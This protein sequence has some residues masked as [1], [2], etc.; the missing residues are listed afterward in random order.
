MY[1]ATS[2][3]PSG[4]GGDY[5]LHNFER[6]EDRRRE[7]FKRRERQS[8]KKRMKELQTERPVLDTVFRLSTSQIN[9]KRTRSSQISV[10]NLNVDDNGADNNPEDTHPLQPTLAAEKSRHSFLYLMLSPH[11]RTWQAVAFRRFITLVIMTDLLLF[12]WSTDDAFTYLSDDFYRTA[13]GITS[14]IFLLEYIGRVYT[15]GE[16]KK[17]REMGPIRGRL[18]FMKTFAAVIDL[19]AALPFFLEI[20]TGWNLPTLT[21]LRFLRLFRILKS[22][23]YVKALDAVYRVIYFNRQILYVATLVCLFLVLITSILLYYCRPR[24]DRTNPL[25]ESLG[26]TMYMSTLMLTGGGAPDTED[27]PFM[28]KAVVLLTSVFSVAMFAIP[29]SM[30]TWGFEAEA[31]RMAKKARKRALKRREMSKRGSTSFCSS[32]SSDYSSDGNTT[33]EEYFKL[34]AGVEE[35][36]EEETPWMKEQR[37]KFNLA[38]ADMDGTLTLKEYMKLQEQ[39]ETNPLEP[40]Q[41]LMRLQ[42][43]EVQVADNSSKLARILT[44]LEQ[45][46]TK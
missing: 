15:V 11:S 19:V 20:P 45:Q 6:T 32:S 34:I 42:A 3:Q 29:A 25:F 17:Y 46:Q 41:F 35:E 1:G 4:N 28:T 8:A 21:Y 5:A 38:D 43:L 16:K 33:D 18:A 24:G 9:N 40:G 2:S 36:E 23:D 26:S 22:E 37:R 30:L 27:L 31:E 10:S 44:L 13:E 7:T 14:T 12:I 39:A